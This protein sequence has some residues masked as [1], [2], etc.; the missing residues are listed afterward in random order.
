[1]SDVENMLN[2]DEFLQMMLT[3]QKRVLN[4]IENKA[5]NI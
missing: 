5:W 2:N 1:M 3:H 4:N